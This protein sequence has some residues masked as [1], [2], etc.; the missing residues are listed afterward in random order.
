MVFIKL[1]PLFSFARAHKAFFIEFVGIPALKYDSEKSEMCPDGSPW[2]RQCSTDS[3]CMLDDE[4]CA[5]R[6]CCSGF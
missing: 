2:H 4:I 5:G 6:K 1:L 3:D